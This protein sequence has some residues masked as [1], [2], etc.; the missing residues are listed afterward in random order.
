MSGYLLDRETLL[1][2]TV[3]IIPLVIIAFFF[4]LFALS[5]G[6]LWEPFIISVSLGLLV[7]PF[8][9][10]GIVTYLSGWIIERD[11]KKQEIT[12]QETTGQETTG[13]ETTGQETT[14]QET[15]G[16]ETTGQETTG[17]E[18]TEQD[19]GTQ[20]RTEQNAETKET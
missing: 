2:V 13:Q 5:S 8:A 9:L 1:D 6:Y 14:G 15:T 10:L 7:V 17:Q 16:Q 12:G 20:N 19:A 18:T 11:E 4:A 3:N